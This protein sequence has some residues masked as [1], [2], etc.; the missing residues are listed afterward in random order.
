MIEQACRAAFVTALLG[1]AVAIASPPAI[2]Q[3]PDEEPTA[4]AQ[5]A[6]KRWSFTGEITSVLS[7]G[8]A[9]ATTFGIGGLIRNTAS[10]NRMRFEAG[11]IRTESAVVTRRAVGTADGYVIETDTRTEK[12]AESYFLRTR[13][14][15]V[16]SEHFFAFWGL[17]WLRN[18]F[19]GIDSR[20]LIAAG[21]GNTWVERDAVRFKTDYAATYTFQ[22]DIVTNPFTKS[23][24]P[25]VRTSWEF[26]N[27]LTRNTEFESVLI[28]DMNLED[29][30]DIRL[31]FRN[32]ITVAISDVIALKPS[33]QFGWRNQPALTSVPLFDTVG[34][35]L[36]EFVLAP[37]RKLDTV[38][39]LALVVKT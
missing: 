25:G 14:D 35:P 7:Q 4:A 18:T 12:T 23:N 33:L 31:D 39:R 29:T 28:S 32:A 30:D 21:A 8:N 11:A 9:D 38:F 13:Y 10:R 24:F 27:R 19:A 5:E 3:E 34:E 22:S 20:F 2:A 1:P 15:R 37:L 16:V 26:W 6:E 17:D 36:D